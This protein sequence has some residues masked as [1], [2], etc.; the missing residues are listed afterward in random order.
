MSTTTNYALTKPTVAGDTDAWGGELNTDLDA[1][2]AQM[3]TN[4]TA[5]AAAVPKAG[6]TMTGNLGLFTSTTK[7]VDLGT[8][9]TPAID[10]A[11]ANSFSFTPTAGY[12]PTLANIP[13]SG[14]VTPLLLEVSNG[15]AFSPTWPAAF[16]FPSSSIP[17]MTTSGRDIMA[18]VCRDGTNFRF[19]GITKNV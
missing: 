2:D 15:G 18:F 8:T 6:G 19:L 17:A 14:V 13:A 3:F 11:T 9:N 1:I 16:K 4:A 12:T 7:H 5:A 10:F